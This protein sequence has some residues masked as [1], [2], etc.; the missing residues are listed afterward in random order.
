MFNNFLKP[1]CLL[2]CLLASVPLQAQWGKEKPQKPK[3]DT[4]EGKIP[5][6]KIV[7]NDL[8]SLPKFGVSANIFMDVSA[9]FAVGPQLSIDYRVGQN[10]LLDASFLYS[11]FPRETDDNGESLNAGMRFHAGGA[12]LFGKS[13]KKKEYKIVVKSENTG[14]RTITNY[15]VPVKAKQFRFWDVRAGVNYFSGGFGGNFFTDA[16]PGPE[17][18]RGS[19]NGGW[20]VLQAGIGRL[21]FNNLVVN[22]EGYGERSQKSGS[23]ISFD[24]LFAMPGNFSEIASYDSNFEPV[25]TPVNGYVKKNI[26]WQLGWRMMPISA[27]RFNF[28]ILLGSRPGLMPNDEVGAFTGFFSFWTGYTFSR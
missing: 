22:V 27:P 13:E 28:G 12:F 6:V 5:E 18:I 25:T 24:L 14:Y 21:K 16:F 11:P 20:A 1:L 17:G 26:G 19:A 7:K 10:I 8:K 23:E 3:D 9:F 4:E 15:F 2:L